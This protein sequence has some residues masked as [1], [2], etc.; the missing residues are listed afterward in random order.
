MNYN[1]QPIAIDEQVKKLKSRGLNIP[2]EAKAASYLSNISYYRLRAYTY[3][4]FIYRKT[5]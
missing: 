3:P 1:K 4:R 2:D 5:L